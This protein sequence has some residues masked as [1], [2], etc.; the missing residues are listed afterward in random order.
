M[1]QTKRQ[2]AIMIK[3]KEN[4]KAMDLNE[5]EIGKIVPRVTSALTKRN[6]KESNIESKVLGKVLDESKRLIKQKRELELRKDLEE[7]GFSPER[8]NRIVKSFVE[9]S[10]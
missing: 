5:Q 10:E 4:Q 7:K 6:I 8:Q 2:I 3:L 1:V 9:F